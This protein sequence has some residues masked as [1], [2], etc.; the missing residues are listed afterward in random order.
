M[1]GVAEDT[2]NNCMNNNCIKNMAE[3]CYVSADLVLGLQGLKQGVH[4]QFLGRY[5]V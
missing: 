1:T 5:F 2:R 4:G 3:H